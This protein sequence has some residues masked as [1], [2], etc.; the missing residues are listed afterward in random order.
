MNDTSISIILNST[1]EGSTPNIIIIPINLL[2]YINDSS[3]SS[4][5]EIGWFWVM[6]EIEID[7]DFSPKTIKAHFIYR[8]LYLFFSTN[9]SEKNFVFLNVNSIYLDLGYSPL[10]SENF[11]LCKY[12][13]LRAYSKSFVIGSNYRD[14]IKLMSNELGLAFLILK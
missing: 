2:K 3:L 9:V 7:G 5:D 13:N 11:C 12:N 4:I 10:D 8:D 1:E 14:I 6:T